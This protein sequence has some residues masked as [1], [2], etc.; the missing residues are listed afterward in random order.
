MASN[1]P[2]LEVVV[3]T[4]VLS[5]ILAIIATLVRG[6]VLLSNTVVTDMVAHR[7]PER[8]HNKDVSVS[9]KHFIT[10][11]SIVNKDTDIQ[12]I[13]VSIC[14]GVFSLELGTSCFGPW[15]NILG[16]LSVE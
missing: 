5:V 3:V 7:I 11:N 1:A 4:V 15:N 10:S 16:A 9:A 14:F 8:N 2:F 13:R 12:R 6:Q